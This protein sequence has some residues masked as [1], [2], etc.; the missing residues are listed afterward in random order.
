MYDGPYDES[1]LLTSAEKRVLR[2]A[3]CEESIF[4]GVV[5][6]KERY[7]HRVRVAQYLEDRGYLDSKWRI[8]DKGKS[9]VI[10]RFTAVANEPR[11]RLVQFVRSMTEAS[12][13]NIRH[14]DLNMNHYLEML[15][16]CMIAIDSEEE[17]S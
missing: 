6:N 4:T 10:G 3:Y 1:D 8:S 11:E 14:I 9:V 12:E 13:R 7:M 17:N 2:H 15:R 5:G 16:V